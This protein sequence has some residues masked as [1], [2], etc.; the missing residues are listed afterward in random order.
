M[1][2]WRAALQDGQVWDPEAPLLLLNDGVLPG[3]PH[4]FFT[5]RHSKCNNVWPVQGVSTLAILGDMNTMAH[6]IAR[7]SPAY[8][9]D[10]LRF[11][12]E[13]TM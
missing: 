11:W 9:T 2:I 8:C 1:E 4:S 3:S 13:E 6:G 12:Y 7:L 5:S 10:R